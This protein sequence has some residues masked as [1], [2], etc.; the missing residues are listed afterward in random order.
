[1]AT[2]WIASVFLA[3]FREKTLDFVPERLYIDA[4]RRQN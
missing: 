2:E 3:F 4:E 1:M